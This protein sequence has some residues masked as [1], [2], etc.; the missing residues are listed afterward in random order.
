MPTN[1]FQCSKYVQKFD[2]YFASFLY[3]AKIFKTSSPQ[4][5]L[6]KNTKFREKI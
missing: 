3:A 1:N 5:I 2:V 4:I 6:L